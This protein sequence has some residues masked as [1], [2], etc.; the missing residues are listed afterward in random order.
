[1]IDFKILS[2]LPSQQEIMQQWDLSNGGNP[3]V[4]VVCITYNQ[5]CY[6]KDALNS[7]LQQKTNFPFE[8]IIHDDASFDSTSNILKFYQK[9]YPEIIKLI[10]KTENQFSKSMYLPIRN[11]F[12]LVAPSSKYIALCEGDDFWVHPDKLQYQYDALEEYRDIN[13]CFTSAFNLNNNGEIKEVYKYSDSLK[14]FSL[15]EVVRGGGGF[16]PTA[17]LFFRK[18]VIERIPIWIIKAPVIDYYLQMIA[19]LDNGSLFIPMVSCVYRVNAKGS[20]TKS[21]SNISKEKILDEHSRRVFIFSE[22]SLLN[23]N[24]EDLNYAM[25]F[26]L[27]MTSFNLMMNGYY[28]E[29]KYFIKKSW[30]LVPKVHK[31]QVAIYWNRNNLFLL[32]FLFL[33]RSFFKK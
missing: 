30:D 17:S 32:R 33:I 3:K 13:I 23:I 2:E 18:E 22:L 7:F 16:M 25:A 6:I 29:S 12:D 5:E 15:S 14:L 4:S 1:M 11:C 10:L 21:R 28:S 19:S 9:K 26:S 27:Y 8:I 24:S 31:L 20:W